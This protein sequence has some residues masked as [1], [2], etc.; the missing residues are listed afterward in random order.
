MAI[1]VE[2]IALVYLNGLTIL[3]S[4]I[5]QFVTFLSIT[6]F[7]NMYSEAILENK[8]LQ[9]K[10]KKVKRYFYK[11]HIKLKEL[12][13]QEYQKSKFDKEFIKLEIL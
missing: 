2:F 6:K 7:D 9:A 1:Y 12:F 5:V 10:N 3:L 8:I 13:D 4:I 11:S